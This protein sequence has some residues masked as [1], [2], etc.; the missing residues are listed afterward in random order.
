MKKLLE[1]KT[2]YSFVWDSGLLIVS[3]GLTGLLFAVFH[4]AMK[5]MLGTVDYA[6]VVALLALLN[7]MALPV[8]A[9]RMT[10]SRFVAEHIH[11]NAGEVW[12]TIYKRAI[13]R[14]TMVGLAAMIGWIVFAVPLKRFFKAP[15]VEALIILG[16][17]AV[18]RLYMPVITGV[19]QGSRRF[20][21]LAVCNTLQ[22]VFRVVFSV[23]VVWLGGRVAGVM[24]AV[25]VSIVLSMLVGWIPFRRMVSDIEPISGYDTR[26]IYRYLVP[27]LIGQGAFLLLMNSDVMFVKRFL[28]GEYE[29]LV[30]AYAQAA[31]LSRVV[32]MLSKPLTGAMFPRAVNSSRPGLFFGPL[33]AALLCSGGLAL[34]LSFFPEIPFKLM[35][36]TDN[37]EC[38]R[39]ARMYI[40]AALPLSL[41]GMTVKYLLARHQIRSCL[42]I[43]FPVGIYLLLLFFF[44]RTPAQ[45]ISCLAVG[46]WGSLLLLLGAVFRTIRT[47]EAA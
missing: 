11:N 29:V 21:V 3:G 30:P 5:R 33:A 20:G 4:A 27:A 24:G 34:L 47:T 39:I 37:P 31:T 38:F 1:L 18:V 15:S 9:M 7:V 40:W 28:Y 16:I 45:I 10:I 2:K 35:Y 23:I 6:S 22:P 42:L 44:H 8:D 46:S 13:R 36:G 14:I 32:F 25:A 43:V 41:S 12:V 17:I 26:H 19:L